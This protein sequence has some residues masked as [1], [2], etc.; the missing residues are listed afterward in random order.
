MLRLQNLLKFGY[1]N[2]QIVSLLYGGLGLEVMFLILG[3]RMIET[4]KHYGG[5]GLE[6]MFLILGI[7]M[8]ETKK[9]KTQNKTTK[10]SFLY[11]Y[12]EFILKL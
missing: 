7:R 5:L 1:L 11:L 6:V 2:G 3:I 10:C 4:K 9:Q 12:F 8:I